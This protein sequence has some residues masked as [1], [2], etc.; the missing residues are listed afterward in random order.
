MLQE[1]RISIYQLR[2]HRKQHQASH[3]QDQH[4]E[5]VLKLPQVD[6]ETPGEEDQAG[7]ALFPSNLCDNC[8]SC[9]AALPSTTDL[10]LQV[11]TLTVYCLLVRV[12][13][14]AACPGTQQ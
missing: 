14:L 13:R 7:L 8:S 9:P 11:K 2:I 5:G 1:L 3:H 10:S 12:S 6:N 4:Q